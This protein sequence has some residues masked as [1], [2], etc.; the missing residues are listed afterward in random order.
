[1]CGPAFLP[2]VLLL[3]GKGLLPAQHLLL[4]VCMLCCHAQR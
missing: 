4:Q 2:E 1:M 3:M